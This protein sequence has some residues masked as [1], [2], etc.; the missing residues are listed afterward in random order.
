M[1][2]PPPQDRPAEPTVTVPRDRVYELLAHLVAS[3]DLCATEP[4]YYG[5]FRLLDGAAKLA[6]IALDCGLDD[7]WLAG[8]HSDVEQNK[9]LMMSDREAYFGYLPQAAGAVA[10]RLVETAP[11]DD[12]SSAP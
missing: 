4:A 3:A 1:T 8:F 9:L 5:T 7:D 6:G 12:P 11:L 2:T 10:R